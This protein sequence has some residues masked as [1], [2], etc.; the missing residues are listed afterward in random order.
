MGSQ[1]DVMHI[2]QSSDTYST[3]QKELSYIQ[4][5]AYKKES[6]Y[7]KVEAYTY[8]QRSNLSYNTINT[9]KQ[10][11]KCMYARRLR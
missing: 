8:K 4:Q 2:Q 3:I 11:V 9:Y 10:T 7:I 6:P 5:H 1:V